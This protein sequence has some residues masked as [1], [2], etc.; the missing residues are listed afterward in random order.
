MLARLN[1]Y[2]WTDFECKKARRDVPRDAYTTVSAFANSGGGWL[3]FG[4]S[5]QDSQ[6]QTS[7][8][9]PQAFDRVQND[10]L[11]TLRSA[12]KLNQQINPEHQVFEIDGKRVLA[13]YIP[14]SSRQEK[15]VYLNNNPSQ[16]YIRQGAGDLKASP[17][18]LRRFLRDASLQSWDAEAISGYDPVSCIDSDTVSWYQTQFYRQNPGQREIADPVE[19]LHEWNFIVDQNGSYL[20]TRAAVLLF[21]ADRCLRQLLPRPVLDYQRIDTSADQWSADQRWNDRVVYEENLFKTWRNLVAKYSRIAEHPFKVDSASLRR[22]DDPPDYIAFREASINILIHQDYGD[23]HRKASLKWFTDQIIFWNPGDGFTTLEELLDATEKEVRN[24][25]IVSAFRR[26]GLSDQAGTG[27]RAIYRNWHELKRRQPQVTNDKSHKNFELVLLKEPAITE[28]MQKFQTSLGVHLAENEAEI[29]AL[30]MNADHFSTLEA[31]MAVGGDL[32]AARTA[33]ARLTQQ[34]LLQVQNDRYALADMIRSRLEASQ[35]TPPVALKA[36]D[37]AH[38]KAHDEA[39]VQINN[40]EQEILRACLNGPLSSKDLLQVLG[41]KS[42]TG[43][44]KKAMSRLL[45]D[46]HLLEKTLPDATQSKHQQYRITDRGRNIM[47][48]QT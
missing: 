16:T 1:G 21:G 28:A 40:T 14:E 38:E 26:I 12:Q 10:F 34:Q 8:V 44:F 33:L 3:L 41:Y 7:G 32:R 30:A 27:I 43:N 37:E 23:V 24:P 22:N 17:N 2:E 35:S 20:L 48:N 5:E 18:E 6:F 46:L 39:H 15:P 45:D 29:L 31:G 36:Q 47:E 25:L 42:R 11:T 4:V 19:F 9:D 13:F